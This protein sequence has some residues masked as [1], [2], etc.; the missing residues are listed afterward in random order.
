MSSIQDERGFNQIF[1]DSPAAKIRRER[2]CDYMLEQMKGSCRDVQP[3]LL[4]IGCGTGE[5]LYY[6][7]QKTGANC[8]GIDLSK[9]FIDAANH[10]FTAAHLHFHQ[11]DFHQIQSFLD[12]IPVSKFD[13]IVGNGILHHLYYHLNRSLEDLHT[14]LKPNGKIIFIEPNL[15]NPYVAAIFKIP[16]FRKLA[17]LEP[18]E[19]AF[20]SQFIKKQLKNEKFSQYSIEIKDFL[21]PNVPTKLINPSIKIG[22]FLE[23]TPFRLFAQSLFITAT[24]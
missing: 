4:E 12:T 15:Y 17:H 22:G 21:L 19:M 10:Q 8:F 3:N 24:K 9:K 20:T 23:K 7:H 5:G 14:L 13:Y 2:R 1:T 11:A 16:Y 6:L 18:N